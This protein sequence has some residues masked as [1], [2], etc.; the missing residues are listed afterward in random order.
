MP[1]A[2]INDHTKRS[3]EYPYLQTADMKVICMHRQNPEARKQR[4]QFEGLY[5]AILPMQWSDWQ[6]MEN[7]SMKCDSNSGCRWKDYVKL[8]LA[9]KRH[10]Y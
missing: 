4:T 1:T 5:T 10:S 8:Q 9:L 7:T 3:F 6:Q 2:E